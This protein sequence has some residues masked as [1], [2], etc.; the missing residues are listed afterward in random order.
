[1]KHR[2]TIFIS[3][4]LFIAS[5]LIEKTLLFGFGIIVMMIGLLMIP[6]KK[7]NDDKGKSFR[8]NKTWEE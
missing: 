7:E 8:D 3:I 5:V 1:M 2:I 4:L 6:E